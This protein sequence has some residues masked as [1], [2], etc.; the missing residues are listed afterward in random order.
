MQQALTITYE[1]QPLALKGRLVR[2]GEPAPV[3]RVVNQAYQDVEIG[4]K[5]DRPQ[6]IATVPT[7]DGQVCPEEVEHLHE[8]LGPLAAKLYLYV[9]SMDLPHAQR[10]YCIVYSIK[11]LEVL[12]DFRYRELEKYGVLIEGG[13]LKGLLAR[14]LFLVDT[15]GKVAYVQLVREQ[16]YFPDYEELQGAIQ[17][18]IG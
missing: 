8:T 5:K 9:V 14:A 7:L 6:L 15:E 11:H 10:R 1:G 12:S 4:G 3:V 18:L 16:T 2:A 17:K 13:V